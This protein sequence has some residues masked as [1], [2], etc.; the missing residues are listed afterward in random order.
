[1]VSTTGGALLRPRRELQS[2]RKGLLLGILLNLR[3]GK[4]RQSALSVLASV[5]STCEVHAH[6]LDTLPAIQDLAELL[7][8]LHER[9]VTLWRISRRVVPF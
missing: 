4:S 8:D 5:R 6:C 7:M 9:V 1:M 2:S 3:G